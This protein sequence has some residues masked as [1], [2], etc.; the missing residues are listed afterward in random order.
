MI[1]D[2]DIATLRNSPWAHKRDPEK[3]SDN[4]WP[5]PNL[6]FGNDKD[7]SA[8]DSSNAGNGFDAWRR[9][10]VPVGPRGEQRLHSMRNDDVARLTASKRLADVERDLDKW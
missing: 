6:A 5:F 4:L 2:Y 10:V 3:F 1:A 7:R 8:F 9:I